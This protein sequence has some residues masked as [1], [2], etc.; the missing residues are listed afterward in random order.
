[1]NRF[2]RF[3]WGVLWGVGVLLLACALPQA[4]PSSSAVSDLAL[5]QTAVALQQTQVALQLTVQAA[6]SAPTATATVAPSA[7]PVEPTATATLAVSP[8][9]SPEEGLPGQARGN[10]YCRTG[11]A[12]YYPAIDT[13]HADDQVVI[14][15][16]AAGR[17]DY[18]LVQTP[19]GKTCWVWG[20]WLN[21]AGD[22]QT[23]PEATP[24]P[25]PPAAVSVTLLRQDACWGNALV[26]SVVN[27]GP[28][29][30]E[31]VRFYIKDLKTGNSYETPAI[32]RDVFYYCSGQLD[33]LDPAEDVEVWVDIGG[34]DLRGHTVQVTVKTCT[35]E[36]LQGQ[37]IQRPPFNVN[38]P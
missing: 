18:W 27:R 8:T 37:C 6:S 2:V 26:F 21:I 13:M 29:P 25:A 24:P 10:L 5:T 14:L 28:T 11:P 9:T 31:S 20:R 3:R 16:R 30:I 17:D 1:V 34:A 7:T 32:Q 33:T 23:L 22:P 4:A 12:P 35:E 19:H 15:A 38:V 36:G